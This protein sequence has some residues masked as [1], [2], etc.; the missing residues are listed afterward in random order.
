MRYQVK[1]IK[2]VSYETHI[3][4]SISHHSGFKLW[5]EKSNLWA[6]K[7][8][9]WVMKSHFWIII[10]SCQR[11]L[12]TLMHLFTWHE[13][14]SIH[15]SVSKC[16]KCVFRPPKKTNQ[17]LKKSIKLWIHRLMLGDQYVRAHRHIKL[18][19]NKPSGPDAWYV[20]LM[21]ADCEMSMRCFFVSDV[22]WVGWW[23]PRQPPHK[24]RLP[25]D[26][27]EQSAVFLQRSRPVPSTAPPS[28]F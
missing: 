11:C 13:W 18:G 3:F 24:K 26:V 23:R 5:D 22:D 12:S 9:L 28:C 19:E 14:V 27:G 21:R 17:L 6:Q 8:M 4:N 25:H 15:S 2:I 20:I 10:S 7:S 1:F 16:E